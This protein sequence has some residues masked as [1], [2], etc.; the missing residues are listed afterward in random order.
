MVLSGRNTSRLKRQ[1]EKDDG[2]DAVWCRGWA[3]ASGRRPF[4]QGL[5]DGLCISRG[6]TRIMRCCEG[7]MQA[8]GGG[9]AH[10]ETGGGN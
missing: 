8:Y 6:S 7:A 1:L 3:G 2:G 10:A 5:D 4:G 9:S